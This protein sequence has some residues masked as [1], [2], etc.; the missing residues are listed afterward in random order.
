MSA[1]S[2]P[3]SANYTGSTSP[4]YTQQVKK[5]VP[6]GTV[7]SDLTSPIHQADRPTFTAT[8][9]NPVAPLGSASPPPTSSS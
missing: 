8:F 5:P 6:T 9:V 7:V 1:R 3:V 4:T 2:T